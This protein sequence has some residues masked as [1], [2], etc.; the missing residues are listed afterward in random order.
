MAHKNGASRDDRL[1]NLYWATPKENSDDKRRHGTVVRGNRIN[2]SKLTDDDV[3]EMR[4]LISEGWTQTR[5]G[6]KFGV[7]QAA[8]SYIVT[9]RNWN[10]LG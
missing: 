3:R 10:H 5:V 7:S 2:T 9:R 4:K 1:S 8:V 6:L